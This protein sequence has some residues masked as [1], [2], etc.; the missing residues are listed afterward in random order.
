MERPDWPAIAL[1]G[2]RVVN[3]G[4]LSRDDVKA[5]NALVRQGKLQRTREY[6]CYM[7][8]GYIGPMKTVWRLPE[9][10]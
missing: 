6:W 2:Q 9:S 7:F 1:S 5:L 4:Q 10:Q 8:G 3:I